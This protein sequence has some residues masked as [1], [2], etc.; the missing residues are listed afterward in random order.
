MG[1]NKVPIFLSITVGENDSV[2]R[3]LV[4]QI[5][6]AIRGSNGFKLIED[7]KQWPYI[8]YAIVT[9]SNNAIAGNTQTVVSHTITYDNVDIPLNGAFITGY[10]QYCGAEVVQSCAA[11][12]MGALDGAVDDLKRMAP[13]L[14][15]K[16]K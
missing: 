1:Q 7:Q 16:L 4:F 13:Q 12:T 10:I 2:G 11:R 5:K 8:H 6:E 9:M 14:W 3:Q 15:K